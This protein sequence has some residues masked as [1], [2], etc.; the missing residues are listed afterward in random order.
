MSEE[1]GRYSPARSRESEQDGLQHVGEVL[2]QLIEERRWP[3]PTDLRPDGHD[4]GV[5]SGRWLSQ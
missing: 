4:P 2:R 3:T 1:H 5:R